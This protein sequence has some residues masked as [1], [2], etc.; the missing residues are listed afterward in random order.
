MLVENSY[1]ENNYATTEPGCINNCGQ[2]IVKTLHFIKTVHFGGLEQ[3]T[4]TVEQIQQ[5]MI[6]ISQIM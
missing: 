5:Y 2:L 1:F 4:L 6:L 3:Y